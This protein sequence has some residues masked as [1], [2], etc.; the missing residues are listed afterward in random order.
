MDQ[1]TSEQLQCALDRH[2][3]QRPNANA[4]EA[5]QAFY[6]GVDATIEVVRAIVDGKTSYDMANAKKLAQD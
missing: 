1:Q 5:T 4:K 2:L 6:A 3:S